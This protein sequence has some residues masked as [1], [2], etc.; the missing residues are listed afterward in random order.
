MS[1][2]PDYAPP[3][4]HEEPTRRPWRFRPDPLA[5]TLGEVRPGGPTIRGPGGH[6]YVDAHIREVSMSTRP[7][8]GLRLTLRLTIAALVAAVIIGVIKT[9]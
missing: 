2:K 4:R 5:Q 9:L 3:V 6:I 8:R 1:V 7:R